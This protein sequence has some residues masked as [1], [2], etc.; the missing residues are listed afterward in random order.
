MIW[1]VNSSLIGQRLMSRFCAPASTKP[2]RNPITPSPA[3]ASPEPVSQADKVTNQVPFRS[4]VLTSSAVRIPSSSI[5][6]ASPRF[7]AS[8][9]V[10][11]PANAK[12]LRCIGFLKKL[13][14]VRSDLIPS[15]WV[16]AGFGSEET[17]SG[18]K[19]PW[20]QVQNVRAVQVQER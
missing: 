6:G 17:S 1:T 5:G 7:Q 19:K 15:A 14:L 18:S 11:A 16:S 20:V 10:L 2:R 13:D 12:P 8:I 9:V 3:L 4:R